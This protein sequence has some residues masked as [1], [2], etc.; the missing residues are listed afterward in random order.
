MRVNEVFKSIQGEGKY[1]G[2]PV[3]FVRLSGCTR[4]CDF[5]DTEYPEDKGD[6]ISPF[7]MAQKIIGSGMN[8]VV[9]SG[10]EPTLQ[11]KDI[12]CTIID[13]V[14]CGV[15]V[16]HHLETNGDLKFNPWFF[17][18]VC[19]SPKE[20]TAMTSVTETLFDGKQIFDKAKYDIKVVT[21]LELNKLLLPFATMLM[22]ITT[23]NEELNRQIERNL[24]NMCVE[25]N[26]R[27]CLRQHVH[28]WGQ[29]RGV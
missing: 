2:C 13:L 27:F 7:D 11:M 18:Y 26:L 8:T 14:G 10:G 1:A 6:E 28:V 21:D 15:K 22:P 9:W 4:H 23:K 12:V 25:K 16:A 17:D 3:L 20:P 29:K 24:W 19:F 5:C